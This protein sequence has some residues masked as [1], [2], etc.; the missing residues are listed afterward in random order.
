MQNKTIWVYIQ[1]DHTRIA[2]VSLEL[3]TK[4]RELGSPVEA[5][6]FGALTEDMIQ[7]LSDHGANEIIHI[8]GAAF[9]N[10]D[11]EAYT[12]ALAELLTRRKPELLLVG[13]TH[14]GRDLCARLSARLEL[15]MAADAT[16]VRY[17]EEKGEY[18]FIR[19]TYDGKSFAVIQSKTQP[20][21]ATIHPGVFPKGRPQHTQT[22]AVSEEALTP[23]RSTPRV[24]ILDFVE[25]ASGI[26][27]DLESAKVIVSGGRGLGGPEGFKV[28]EDLADALGGA[29]GASKPV[30]DN[31]W[32]SKEHQVGVTGKRVKPKLY[33]AAG[34]SGAIQHK[35][36]M[37]DADVI[38]AINT[39][40]TAPIFDF[41]NYGIVG[42]LFEI[43][44]RLTALIR[45]KRELKAPGERKTEPKGEFF[46][47]APKPEP[48]KPGE[49]RKPW[50]APVPKPEDTPAPKIDLKAKSVPKQE[51]GD[52]AMNY[53]LDEA[54]LE[55]RKSFREFA[56]QVAGPIA[57]EID[58]NERFP[59]ENI[60]KMAEAGLL[61]IPFPEEYGGTGLDNLAYAMC[62]E[63]LS[64]VCGTHGVIVSA[65]TSLGSWPIYNFGTEEQK[66]KYLV[67]LA[68][69]EKLGAFGLTEP[70]AGTDAAGQQ[71]TAVPDGDDYIIN[72]SKI[73]ITNGGE[74]DTYVVF[75]M[76]E[77]EK[78]NHGIT[79]FIMEKGMP[80][81]TIGKK[82]AKMGIRGSATSE[83]FFKDVRVPKENLL[84]EYNKGF[85]VAMMTLDGGRIGIAS[86]ALGLAQGAL[87]ATIAY[88]KGREQFGKRIS[89]FQNTQFT[90][91]NMIARVE[92]ARL[93][94][95]KAAVAKDKHQN[96]AALAAMAKLV[97]S[98]AARDVTC[99]AV[100]L[101][102]GY[103]FTRDYP[104]ERM[105]RDAKI[106]EI[107]EGTS[108]VQR[109]VI[110]AN[111]GIK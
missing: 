97:A 106:T 34:I 36:G 67:P 60:P 4:A 104:V 91:A 74:A 12:D 13:A 23:K 19:P 99:Q 77:P 78:G 95:Y 65:H 8:K 1:H 111:A 22:A 51:E 63:E 85:K 103:G 82:L 45:E 25:D 5:L 3:L 88:T 87:D 40:P 62:V 44:P 53:D 26:I 38:L 71:T 30:V 73:F 9:E 102:G 93:L 72:G 79:A 52:E 68:S 10:Y 37:Q 50:V 24:H 64:R 75:T 58:E 108:E 46:G 105:M 49:E 59:R 27:D 80:G 81:F 55:L 89:S 41:A 110:A 100:Q 57:R 109:M 11:T 90:I 84:G 83:L 61:G 31:G 20:K 47:K 7:V 76:T 94:I 101:F 56:E 66:R 70:N 21:I 6:V 48:A 39:D 28:I 29:V 32:I 2:R 107:Y 96:Y 17:D 18:S 15:G 42:D 14:D 69:G 35:L 16:D 54:H 86:Q 43:L 98:E 33:I 92:A